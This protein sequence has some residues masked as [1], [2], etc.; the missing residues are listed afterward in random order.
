LALCL[1][2]VVWCCW[3]RKSPEMMEGS[4]FYVSGT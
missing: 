2:R 3:G 4:W 1:L